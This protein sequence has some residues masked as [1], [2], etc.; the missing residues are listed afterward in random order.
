MAELYS[1][2]TNRVYYKAIDFATGKTVTA[3]FW[4]PS[5]VK[6]ALQA[7]TEIESGLYYLDYNFAGVGSY[8]G[9]FYENGTKTTMSVF[10]VTALAGGGSGPRLE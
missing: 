2:G 8:V 6:S 4:S 3:Y 7:L 5:L 1:I 10:R 9:L